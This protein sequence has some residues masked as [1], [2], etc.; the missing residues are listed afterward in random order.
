VN[1]EYSLIFNGRCCGCE[2]ESNSQLPLPTHSR[3]PAPTS[4]A[5]VKHSPTYSPV[6]CGVCGTLDGQL[7]SRLSL[8]VTCQRGGVICHIVFV[9]F[10]NPSGSCS[11]GQ[12]TYG[13]CHNDTNS[14]DVFASLCI[15]QSQCTLTFAD[16]IWPCPTTAV[17]Y[18]TAALALQADCCGCSNPKLKD[19][20]GKSNNNNQAGNSTLTVVISVIAAVVGVAMLLY[21]AVVLRRRH[22]D[23][24]ALAAFNAERWGYVYYDP[25][26]GSRG[27]SP[28][29]PLSPL[30][31]SSSSASQWK[32]ALPTASAGENI[33][34][35]TAG[36]GGGGSKRDGQTVYVQNIQQMIS[37][38]VATTTTSASQN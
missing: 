18:P 38:P 9:S 26:S 12:F 37:S 3:K 7:N 24:L 1:S 11:T 36:G 21:G 31:P 22:A 20:E 16:F 14:K 17:K 5:V 29:S 15:G 8:H 10:G 25:N 6:P 34:S 27:H 19:E 2:K 13:S 33:A 28:S 4:S 23:T 30:S 35:S 32:V